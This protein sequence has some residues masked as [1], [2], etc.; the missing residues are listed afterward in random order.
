[1]GR[2]TDASLQQA[3]LEAAIRQ[4][5]HEERLALEVHLLRRWLDEDDGRDAD[6]RQRREADLRRAERLVRLLAA[7]D[8]GDLCL[9]EL[10]INDRWSL[11]SALRRRPS[12]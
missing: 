8:R 11:E 5:T 10:S 4:L 7:H 6:E 3:V 12:E 1:M 9:P 2:S